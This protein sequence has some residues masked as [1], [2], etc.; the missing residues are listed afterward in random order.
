MEK[1]SLVLED[2]D[3]EDLIIILVNLLHIL[4]GSIVS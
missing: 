4:L 2:T 1:F 3:N